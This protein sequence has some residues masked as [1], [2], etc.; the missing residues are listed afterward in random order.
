MKSANA[1]WS[2]PIELWEIKRYFGCLWLWKFKFADTSYRDFYH[3]VCTSPFSDAFLFL[4]KPEQYSVIN[5]S[6]DVRVFEFCDLIS[7]QMMS[8]WCPKRAVAIDETILTILEWL[9]E[10]GDFVLF[11]PASPKGSLGV[12]DGSIL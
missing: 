6:L 10:D 1:Y 9:A 12:C 11:I 5:M 4:I 2:Q 3:S 8:G 7:R